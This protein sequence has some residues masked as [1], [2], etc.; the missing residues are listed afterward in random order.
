MNN[1]YSF[2]RYYE[3]VSPEKANLKVM[4]VGNSITVHEIRPELGWNHL[5]G[6]A[7]S[8]L[9]NDY[10]HHVIRFLKGKEDKLSVYV[11]NGKL[12]ELDYYKFENLDY[13]LNEINQYQPDIIIIRIGEN[14]YPAYQ[15]YGYD[16]FPSFNR[17]IEF[18]KQIAKHVFITSL[19]WKNDVID[20]VILKAT[21]EN[22]AFY[23]DIRDLEVPENKAIGLFKNVDVSNHPGDLGMQKI[24]KRI[25]KSIEENVFSK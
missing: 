19:F 10:V 2:P 22:G 12:W 20:D 25:I 21:K 4:F 8:S 15:K 11:Y 17:L 3:G 1:N 24:A 14:V 9:E 18:S 5:C 7:A 16:L 13:I 6:M 23:V